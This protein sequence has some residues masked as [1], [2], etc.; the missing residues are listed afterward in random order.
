MSEMQYEFF[1]TKIEDH[2]A[3]IFLNKPEKRNAMDWSFWR[4]LPLLVHEIEKRK[5]VRV[6]IIAAHG[7][8]FS[9]GLDLQQFFTEFTD[10]FS[11]SVGEERERLYHLILDMQKGINA[12]YDSTIPSIACIQKHCIGGGLDLISACDL[13]YSTKDASISLRE[14]KVGI[15]ADMGSL[16][17]LP[18]LIGEAKTRELAL[19]GKDISGDEAKEMGLVNQTFDTQEEMMQYAKTVALEVASNPRFVVKG[20]KQVLRADVSKRLE[21]NLNLVALW[22]SAFMDSIDFR[23]AIS[24]FKN[25]KKPNFNRS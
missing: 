22:N 19:T 14:V 6:M 17:R 24:S 1:E 11:G 9:T 7:K 12:I 16:Q 2:I 3:T 13:R 4:D 20:V 15:V 8:S 18:A 10:I 23:E 25:K 5:D 21:A